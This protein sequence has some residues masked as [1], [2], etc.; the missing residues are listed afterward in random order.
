M[1]TLV[2]CLLVCAFIFGGCATKKFTVNSTPQGANLFYNNSI[3]GKTPSKQTGKF[4]RTKDSYRFRLSMEGYNDTTFFVY[5]KPKDL[6]EYDL[7]LTKREV[8]EMNLVSY[9]PLLTAAGIRLSR[10]VKRSR[11]YIEDIE[12]SP[13]VRGVTRL[14]NVTD[15]VTQIGAIDVS[16]LGDYLVYSMYGFDNNINVSN[17]W[18]QKIGPNMQTRLTFG[19]KSDLFPAFSGNGKYVYFSSN[20]ITPNAQIWRISVDGGGGI[21]KITSSQNEDYFANSDPE[22]KIIVYNS[23]S[24]DGGEPQIWT[25]SSSGN[26]PTQLREG[27]FPVLSPDGNRIAFIRQNKNN[28]VIEDG[29]EFYPKQIWMMSIDGSN[30]TIL[31]QNNDYNCFQP[32]W[33]P[34]GKYL[35]YVS[36]QGRDNQGVRNNDIWIMDMEGG[37]KTQL[38]TNGSW[39]DYPVWNFKDDFIYFRS[40]RGGNWNIWRFS[41]SL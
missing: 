11:A 16:P 13:N 28:L 31:T 20:R 10:V 24:N 34:D 15:T 30:E 25:I 26:L 7:T 8:V 39:D 1:K 21:T 4:S 19:R 41:P 18:K 37:Q 3:V 35:V 23:K 29:V 17:I 5:Q 2:S 33:S 14:T 32:R 9:E 12:R 40:N 6:V 38:T 22:N 36:D 27:E